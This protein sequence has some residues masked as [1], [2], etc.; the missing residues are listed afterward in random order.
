TTPASTCASVDSS[1]PAPSTAQT[2]I[3]PTGRRRC[4]CGSTR[5]TPRRHRRAARRSSSRA[6]G[7]VRCSSPTSSRGAM[8]AT[9]R[10]RHIRSP[11]TR[12]SRRAAAPSDRDGALMAGPAALG[13]FALV[14]GGVSAALGAGTLGV[15]LARHDTRLLEAGRR[16]IA[17]MVAGAV[18]AFVAMEWALFSHDYSIK[19]VANNVAN[20]TPGLFTF[21]AAWGALEGSI[22]LWMLM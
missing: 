15:G 6:A 1:F 14:A 10:R 17:P 3:S 13:D 4:T 21:T 8:A 7:R 11:T 22:L 19:Y 16:F 9:T 20:A 5:P 2:S 18:L 12:P